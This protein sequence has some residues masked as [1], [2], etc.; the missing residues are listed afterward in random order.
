MLFVP[1]NARFYSN[2]FGI[3]IVDFVSCNQTLE[4]LH[5]YYSEKIFTQLR[6]LTISTSVYNTEEI[7]YVTLNWAEQMCY[8]HN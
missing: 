7:T 4:I 5:Y 8:S 1:L 3:Y 6:V 2:H